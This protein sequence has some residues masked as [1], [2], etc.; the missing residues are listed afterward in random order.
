MNATP[1]PSP[2]D[3]DF[4]WEAAHGRLVSLLVEHSAR[5]I[6]VDL[7]C[8]FA[9]H[10]APLL[11]AGFG[12]VGFDV[13]TDSVEALRKRG[14]D[15]RLLDLAN[16]GGVIDALDAL[17]AELDGPIAAVIAI[18]VIEHLVE[19]HLLVAELTAWMRRNDV[20]HFAVSV[21]NASHRDVA[22]K[23]LAGRW[24]TSRSGLLDHTHLRFFTDR[25]LTAVLRTCGL[26]EVARDD[27]PGPESD[28]HWPADSALLAQA[29]PLGAFLRRV[30][31]HGDEHGAT[32]Q[33]IRIYTPEPTLNDA[34]PSLLSGEPPTRSCFLTVVADPRHDDAQLERLRH[35]LDAQS[36][37]DFE[38]LADDNGEGAD[39]EQLLERARGDYVLIVEPD[40]RLGPELVAQ[41][42]AAPRDGRILR[43]AGSARPD[44]IGAAA[45]ARSSAFAFPAGSLGLLG[46]AD[47]ALP[48]TTSMFLDLFQYCGVCDV[49]A[50]GE[51]TVRAVPPDPDAIER[52][53]AALDTEP[54]LFPAGE[55]SRRRSTSES[56]DIR[57]DELQAQIDALTA[58]NA[59]L[60]AELSAPAVK[61]VRRVLRRRSS[62][63]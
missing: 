41:F 44:D 56:H 14:H 27:R 17:A 30:R 45:S 25:S 48:L 23:L 49:D 22:V 3:V 47:P 61:T 24:D 2:Y 12:F 54:A 53:L 62:R 33:F 13:D 36:T 15:A 31:S 28:Q 8:G 26:R 29:T 37:S 10:V 51:L 20:A 5:G 6:V 21:P 11:D 57:L 38:L 1:P 32:Y 46:Y 52:R 4:D 50:E 16:T 7:G 42:T 58:D 19:P 60:T 59:W 63:T 39:V 34:R 18:D 35:E 40:D 55:F 43:R 9:P